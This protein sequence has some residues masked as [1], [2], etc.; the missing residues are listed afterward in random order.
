MVNGM[1]KKKKNER[2]H[3]QLR[4]VCDCDALE[5]HAR[6]TAERLPPTHLFPAALRPLGRVVRCLAQNGTDTTT[7]FVV[8]T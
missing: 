2:D 6:A 5:V 8:A 4:V 3:Q 7:Y 1:W